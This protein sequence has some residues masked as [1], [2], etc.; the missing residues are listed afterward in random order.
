MK[1]FITKYFIPKPFISY[2]LCLRHCSSV[3][4]VMHVKVV[5]AMEATF[6]IQGILD[7][8]NVGFFP[9]VLAANLKVLCS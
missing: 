8:M 2:L 9:V 5:T 1:T 6:T 7:L 4:L 3:S